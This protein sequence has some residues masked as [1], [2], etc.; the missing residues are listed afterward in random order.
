MS[1]TLT[2]KEKQFIKDHLLDDVHD[3]ALRIKNLTKAWDSDAMFL[4]NQIVGRRKIKEK[5]PSWYENDNLLYP[6]KLSL[7]QASSEK[8]ALYKA[9]LLSGDSLVDLTGGLGVDTA[10]LSGN[11]NRVSYVERQK[12][13]ADLARH[14]FPNL[15]LHHIDVYCEDALSFLN[16]IDPVDAIYIDPARRS[17]TGKK[18]AL[19]SDCE[20][21]II[22]IQEA[23]LQKAKR[24]LIKM[25][26]ML[27]IKMAIS[28]LKKVEEV[29][30]VSVDNECKELLFLMNNETTEEPQIHCINFD[31]S[32][33]QKDSF[34]YSDEKEISLSY[35]DKIK[36]YLYEPNAS[37]MKAGYYKGVARQYHIEKLHP[38]SHLYTSDKY[39]NDFPG[40]TFLV[41]NDLPKQ[42]ANIAVR[43]Y[44]IKPE[45][46]KKKLKLKDGG[47][48]YLFA[49]TLANGAKV[50]IPTHKA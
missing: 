50:L 1:N 43:N 47:D 36:K 39:I 12:E 5:V 29:H 22:D 13:L 24:I 35:T 23:L 46:L 31:K 2:D 27:D 38:D 30:I 48:I 28:Q 9:S 49:T 20:P 8:T 11:F 34:R 4:L 37:I 18:V 42:Q 32:G 21:N 10:F 17:S 45:A 14:N 15:L 16:R 26:P 3:L 7:E 33:A 25:S 44:P 6:A 41:I 40:R 19:I